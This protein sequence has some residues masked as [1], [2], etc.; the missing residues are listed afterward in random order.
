M[1]LTEREKKLIEQLRTVSFGEVVVYMQDSQPVRIEKV[2]TSI[3][4]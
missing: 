3:K 4:L 1:E 2:K